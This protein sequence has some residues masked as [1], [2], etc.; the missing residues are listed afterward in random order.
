MKVQNRLNKYRMLYLPD[1]ALSVKP[2]EV[3]EITEEEFNSE[4]FELVRSSYRVVEEAKE[5]EV[6]EE[7][8]AN[9]TEE[10]EEKIEVA[11]EI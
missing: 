11:E 10:Q 9:E 7:E 1:R 3:V 4:R 2:K 6:I 5:E 8:E